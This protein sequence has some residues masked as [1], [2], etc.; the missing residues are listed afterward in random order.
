MFISEGPLVHSCEG[1]SVGASSVLS[2]TS[3]PLSLLPNNTQHDYAVEDVLPRLLE[4]DLVT[5]RKTRE[6]VLYVARGIEAAHGLLT[7]RWSRAYQELGRPPKEKE[8]PLTSLFANPNME[9]P[10]LP[11]TAAAA[12]TSLSGA[13]VGPT[14]ASTAAGATGLEPAGP[15]TVPASAPPEPEKDLQ[16]RG[17]EARA[18]P[19][20]ATMTLVLGPSTPAPQEGRKPKKG[21]FSRLFMRKEKQEKKVLV[22]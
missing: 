18:L 10:P 5:T 1:W 7:A 3:C 22:A 9:L 13:A 12:R 4:W 15:Q 16:G 17:K 19:D 20:P 2:L 6:G 8:L 11:H 14:R 21:K